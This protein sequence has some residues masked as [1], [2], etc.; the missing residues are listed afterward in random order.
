MNTINQPSSGLQARLVSKLNVGSAAMAIAGAVAMC[1]CLFV[2]RGLMADGEIDLATPFLTGKLRTGSV[3][4]VLIFLSMVVV[5][6][7]LLRRT[8]SNTPTPRQ[9]L[10]VR[11]GDVSFE[12][13]GDLYYLQESSNILDVIRSFGDRVFGNLEGRL[14]DHSSTATGSEPDPV[15]HQPSGHLTSKNRSRTGTDGV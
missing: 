12:W 10:K 14:S 6:S 15:E 1:G 2:W 11:R 8:S 4:V 9:S 13:E 7:A 5:V 3:G